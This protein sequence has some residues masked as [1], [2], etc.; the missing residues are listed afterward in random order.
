MLAFY[1]LSE[2]DIYLVEPIVSG[3]LVKW[4]EKRSI[5]FIFRLLGLSWEL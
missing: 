5:A 2:V 3:R 1:G 4:A